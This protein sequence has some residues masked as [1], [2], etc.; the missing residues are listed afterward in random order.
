MKAVTLW[1]LE[2]G[3]LPDPVAQAIRLIL[4]EQDLLTERINKLEKATCPSPE[5]E[6]LAGDRDVVKKE[7]NEGEGI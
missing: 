3:K 5:E 6:A 4:S 2:H 1:N 7:F